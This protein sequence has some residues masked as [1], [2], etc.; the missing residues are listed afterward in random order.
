ML[1]IHIAKISKVTLLLFRTVWISGEKF[2][3]GQTQTPPTAGSFDDK[4]TQRSLVLSHQEPPRNR[5][6]TRWR[7]R[8]RDGF[9]VPKPPL[10][11]PEHCFVTHPLPDAVIDASCSLFV[12]DRPTLDDKGFSQKNPLAPRPLGNCSEARPGADR[13]FCPGLREVVFDDGNNFPY[14]PQLVTKI[15][16]PCTPST[17]Q[18]S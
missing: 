15:E 13:S 7:L 11:F 9:P 4:R 3:D 12:H 16:M 5:I 18:A 8:F 10:P 6:L 1:K 2:V 17:I 14:Q